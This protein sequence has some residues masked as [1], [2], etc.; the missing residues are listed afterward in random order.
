M[1]WLFLYYK[2]EIFKIQYKIYLKT[3]LKFYE[4]NFNPND[5]NFYLLMWTEKKKK[6]E[7]LWKNIGIEELTFVIN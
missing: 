6:T 4:K 1:K 3:Y 2:K 7:D 5:K